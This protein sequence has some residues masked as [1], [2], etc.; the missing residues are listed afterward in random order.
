ML[1]LVGSFLTLQLISCNRNAI[2]FAFAEAALKRKCCIK[3]KISLF[4]NESF[5]FAAIHSFSLVLAYTTH[6]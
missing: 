2:R 1:D 6:L 3:I 5:L 4:H